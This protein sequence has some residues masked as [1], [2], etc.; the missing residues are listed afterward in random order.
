VVGHGHPSWD[1]FV[2]GAGDRDAVLRRP[3]R[4]AVADIAMYDEVPAA[5]VELR[6]GASDEAHVAR[7]LEGRD[8]ADAVVDQVLLGGAEWPMSGTKI[9]TFLPRERIA[10]ELRATGITEAPK[11]A[12]ARA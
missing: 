3:R 5:F 11:P 4:V 12:S 1:A 2:A 7:D 8:R 10:G 6:P 9:Q